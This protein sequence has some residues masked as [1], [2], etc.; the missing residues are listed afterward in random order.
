MT[1]T[2]LNIDKGNQTTGPQATAHTLA[3]S[4]NTTW[5]VAS[6]NTGI[7]TVS[8]ASGSNSGSVSV[9]VKANT[10]TGSRVATVTATPAGNTAKSYTVTQYGVVFPASFANVTDVPASG[11]GT[12]N[13]SVTSNIP[14]Q[15]TSNQSWCT[16]GSGSQ[17]GANTQTGDT[18]N[19]TYTVSANTGAVRTATITVEGTGSFTGFS[20]TFT[21]TQKAGY[22]GN[23]RPNDPNNNDQTNE[24]K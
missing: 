10:T 19:F 2:W 7:A 24:F 6:N 23:L 1:G 14:W 11:K 12:T 17:T 9:S 5:T 16:I 18:K 15:A 21:V 20:R 3:V 22:Q 13:I 8:P 4:S